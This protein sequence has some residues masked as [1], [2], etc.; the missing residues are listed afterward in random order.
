MTS[1]TSSESPKKSGSKSSNKISTPA[2][3]GFKAG[4]LECVTVKAGEAAPSR[5]QVAVVGFYNDNE[6]SPAAKRADIDTKGLIKKHLEHL[7]EPGAVGSSFL[8]LNP[9]KAG[10]Q[11]Y[12]LVDLGK[13]E[14]YS[15][16][17]LSKATEAAAKAIAKTQTD[18]VFFALNQELPT[19]TSDEQAALLCARLIVASYYH[20]DACKKPSAK[21][22]ALPTYELCSTKANQSAIAKGCELG[23]A[24]G[25][26]M[27]L[28]K[29]LGNLP[30]NICTPEYLASTARSLAK[31]YKLESEILDEKKMAA[32]GMN[33]LLSVGKASSEPPRLIVL[34]YFG[35]SD[36]KAAPVVL[37]GKGITFDT[38][39][40][41]LKP[42][43]GMDEM[44]YDMCGAASVLGTMKAVCEMKLS[45]NLIVVVP[46]AENMPA[47]N[48]S[49]P[50]D[51]VVSMSGQ[52]IEILNTDAEGRLILCDALT[53][54][55]KFNP[56]AVVDV[57]TL[58]G[59]CII[60]LGEVNSGL[61]SPSDELADELFKA[62]KQSLDT[63]WRLPLDEEYHEQLKSNFADMANIGGRSAGSITAACFLQKYTEKYDWA[64]LDIA[65]TAWLSGKAKGASGRPVPLLTEFVMGRAK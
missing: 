14:K 5:K 23:Q 13:K 60:A 31:T 56:S 33:S 37:V 42:G 34:K 7:A 52:T 27:H 24:I 15:K 25:K 30:G 20:F 4:E 63:A 3:F 48:A 53:Y 2:M 22:P 12:L 57:A 26:G 36:K 11:S 59:A 41:S 19:D 10:A 40:I 35:A 17:A 18:S 58:T 44:K 21:N 1:K 62:G 64:H 55:E 8:I 6:L 43:A 29:D 46:T 50:G 39:G 32:L 45:I 9:E 51:I 47:G 61:F 54:V 49:K 28:T 16:K 38:G 65:G